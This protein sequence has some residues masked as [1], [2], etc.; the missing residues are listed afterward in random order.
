MAKQKV[1]TQ[2]K[3]I[4]AL[5]KKHDLDPDSEAEN[6]E[7]GLGDLKAFRYVFDTYNLAFE[8]E[9]GWRGGVPKGAFAEFVGV[10]D[11]VKYQ[12]ALIAPDVIELVSVTGP[13]SNM[14]VAKK[15]S[16]LKTA[17][18]STANKF[19]FDGDQI[20]LPW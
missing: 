1:F 17:M 3:A 6:V 18:N 15:L 20:N 5:C 4:A 7:Y 11:G 19:M 13:E 8:P 10:Q 14:Y 2:I 16:A 12:F 9:T